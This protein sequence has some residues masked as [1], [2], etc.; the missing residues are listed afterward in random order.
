MPVPSAHAQLADPPVTMPAPSVHTQLAYSQQD[1]APHDDAQ[2]G[3][4]AALAP[5]KVDAV[6]ESDAAYVEAFAELGELDGAALREMLAML[7][8][9]A[10][11]GDWGVTQAEGLRGTDDVRTKNGAAQKL[12]AKYVVCYPK[13]KAAW[14]P[15][16]RGPPLRLT[17]VP[18]P[19]SR[20]TSLMLLLPTPTMPPAIPPSRGERAR[21][22]MSRCCGTALTFRPS[23][24]HRSSSVHLGD[25]VRA[26]ARSRV[27]PQRLDSDGVDAA[28]PPGPENR[29]RDDDLDLLVVRLPR[30]TPCTVCLLEGSMSGGRVDRHFQHVAHLMNR[31]RPIRCANF[32]KPK[33]MSRFL[34]RLPKACG[35]HFCFE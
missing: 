2:P 25:R 4:L 20:E 22:R 28:G 33:T 6:L 31:A 13:I 11:K 16:T 15:E 24:V 5:R 23:S 9:R 35:Q 26:V 21:A 14:L 27:N 34:H 17:N 8:N 29:E 30:P 19:I 1:E 7:R 12:M 10:I 3:S 32:G 18:D